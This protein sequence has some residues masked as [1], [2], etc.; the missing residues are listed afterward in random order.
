MVQKEWGINLKNEI[1]LAID[2]HV[3]TNYSKDGAVPIEKVVT[4]CRQKG[5]HGVG[6]IDHNTIEGALKLKTSPIDGFS[7][8]VGEEI[9]TSEGEIT[10]LFLKEWISPGL[11]PEETIDRIKQ[12][13]GLVYITHPF[14]R[15]RR[16]RLRLNALK[17]VVDRVDIIEVFNSRNIFHGD[18][19]KAYAFAKD[20]KKLMMVGSDAHIAY[21]YGKSYIRISPFN[22]A[23]EFK[24]NLAGAEFVMRK[25]PLWVHF[26]TKTKK[27]LSLLRRPKPNTKKVYT[28]GR[29]N[30]HRSI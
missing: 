4:L 23:E 16:S 12:Q 10:G 27:V 17:R 25:S 30:V 6:V 2:L 28:L 20:N 26:A 19:K 5:L 7:I 3:H 29:G 1:V 18:N 13:G 21:E 22:S 9:D 24:R 14:C 11:S 8:I 15:F